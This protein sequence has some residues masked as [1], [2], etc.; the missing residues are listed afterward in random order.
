MVIEDFFKQYKKVAL[1]FS[2]GVDSSYLLYLG[3]K[4]NVDIK[5][6][7][8]KTQFQPEFEFEDAKKLVA[9]LGV[10]M[11]VITLNVL[12]DCK[13]A[14]NPNNRCY[15]CKQ[16]IMGAIK[17]ESEKDG[18]KLIIDGTNASDDSSDRPGMVALKEN[19]VLSPLRLC[20]I[21]KKEIREKSK[22]AGLF[23]WNKPAYACLATR[24]PTEVAITEELLRRTENAEVFLSSIGF[25]DFRV[26]Y[27][28]NMAKIELRDRDLKLLL[29]NKEYIYNILS[30]LYPKGVV[31]DLKSRA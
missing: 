31:L 26:R 27:L 10:E 20:G 1:A 17:K 18:Y 7:Y 6:Y 2:G 29:D 21:T 12:S 4:Y 25:V 30:G 9:S 15:F 24:I 28:D 11:K 23:T 5:P 22:E 3:L 19:G 16:N 14:S 8:V 13:V